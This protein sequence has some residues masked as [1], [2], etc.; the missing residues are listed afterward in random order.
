LTP[1]GG[2]LR[3]GGAGFTHSFS[4][5]IG[6]L[7]GKTACGDYCYAQ[8]LQ[9]HLTQGR[10]GWGEYLLV[11]Q[12]APAVLR[13]ELERASRRDPADRHH[14]SRL[15]I[16]SASST[17]PL[18]GP[19]LPLYKECLRAVAEFPIAA[20]ALQT[21]SPRV[22]DLEAEVTALRGR[23]SVSLTI[24]SDNDRALDFGRSG[25][26]RI[27]ARRRAAEIVSAWP[28]PLHVAVSPMLPLTDPDAFAEWLGAHAD[29][30]TVDTAVDGDGTGTGKRTARTP[31]AE[32][33]ARQGLDWRDTAPARAFHR[34]LVERF[35][36]RAGWSADGFRRLA[37][38]ASLPLRKNRGQ[39]P[40]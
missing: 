40:I 35:G 30:F 1:T 22:V 8:F 28:V 20:W 32:A 34:R 9:S 36:P 10:G 12:N 16:F 11:K 21:R 39:S 29:V 27:D 37:D 19:L 33:M 2:F 4:P 23:I 24:E 26:P 14:V 38:P 5:A 17:E 25:S 18:A 7:L 31:F 3:K 15:R 13:A 6:C